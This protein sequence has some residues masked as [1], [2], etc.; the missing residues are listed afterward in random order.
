ML[1]AICTV[2]TFFLPWGKDGASAT[3]VLLTVSTLYGSIWLVLFLRHYHKDKTV[4]DKA[5]NEEWVNG[6]NY[7]T[8]TL[9]KYSWYTILVIFTIMWIIMLI[10]GGEE[11]HLE[12]VE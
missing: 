11:L 2:A 3:D 6:L 12:L 8:G 9:F 4:L 5:L 10:T 1:Y 7:R